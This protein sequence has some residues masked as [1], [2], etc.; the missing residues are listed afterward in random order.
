MTGSEADASKLRR[1][2]DLYRRLLDLGSQDDLDVFLREALALI[3]EVTAVLHGYLEIH[4]DRGGPGWWIA[5][6]LNT[7]Q[8]AGVRHAI[9]RGIIAEAI[10]T[11]KTIVTPSAQTDPRFSALESVRMS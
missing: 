11:G 7:E 1:E 3:V 8:V 10:A 9:S 4:D 5:H 6:N 2:R